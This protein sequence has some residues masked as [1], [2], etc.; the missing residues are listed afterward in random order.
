MMSTEK[1][2]IRQPAEALACR[3]APAA[4]EKT[5]PS[6]EK[7]AALIQLEKEQ[8]HQKEMESVGRRPEELL[9]AHSAPAAIDKPYPSTEKKAL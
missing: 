7:P 5:V 3:N 4:V 1:M 9:A 6:T 8:K 2:N